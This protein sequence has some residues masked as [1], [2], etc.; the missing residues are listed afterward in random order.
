MTMRTP[1]PSALLAVCLSGLANA[2]P[3]TIA[4]ATFDP[5]LD[6]S[7]APPFNTLGEETASSPLGVDYWILQRDA[8]ITPDWQAGIEAHVGPILAVMPQDCLLVSVAERPN[9]G[10]LA[11]G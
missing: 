2:K 9:G 7:G 5:L 8:R 10:G 3:L 6:A 4:N 11:R 1:L